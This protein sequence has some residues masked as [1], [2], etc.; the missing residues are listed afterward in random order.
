MQVKDKT[1]GIYLDQ[2]GRHA[3]LT[4]DQEVEL[5]RLVQNGSPE[6]SKAARERLINANL[7]LVV[8]LARRYHHDS[9]PFSDLVQEGNIGLMRAVEKFDPER[10]VRF[11]TYAAWWI[12]QAVARYVAV[13][14]RTVKVP[15]AVGERR[16]W[17]RNVAQDLQGQL[18]RV[19]RRDE[20]AE[21]A[22]LPLDD[23]LMLLKIQGETSLDAPVA[24]TDDL[25]LGESIPDPSDAE[26]HDAMDHRTLSRSLHTALEALPD[27]EANILRLRFGIDHGEGTSLAR[28]GRLM[29]LSRE[30]VRQ[31]EAR[32][33][34]LLREGQVEGPL[35]ELSP[36]V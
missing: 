35:A 10:G 26:P 6:E 3:V 18:G 27:R 13:Q 4:A 1:V 34:R 7:R 30:R 29:G 5:G 12:R 2:V 20:L 17:L 19:P 36:A 33:L 21:A 25:K 9:V 24:G 14:H 22:G 23:V 16:K 15:Y 32:A 31:I 28:I 11:S 8:F